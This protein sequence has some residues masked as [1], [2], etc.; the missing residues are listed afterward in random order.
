MCNKVSVVIRALY[1]TQTSVLVDR[2]AARYPLLYVS[3]I[4][5]PLQFEKRITDL[6]PQT[7]REPG[8][9]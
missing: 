7:E 1:T 8:K 3:S 5:R 6:I 9:T 4:V 2:K